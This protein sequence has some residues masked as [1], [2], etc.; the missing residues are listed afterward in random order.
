MPSESYIAK[1]P[2][3]NHYG[4]WT[5]EQEADGIRAVKERASIIYNCMIELGVAIDWDEKEQRIV[6]KPAE[7][8]DAPE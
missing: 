7:K 3:V 5:P 2:A 1:L 8:T 6:I 4:E